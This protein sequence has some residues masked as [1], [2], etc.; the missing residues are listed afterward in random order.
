VLIEP[1]Y[2]GYRIEVFATAVG[3][4]RWNATVRIRRLFT[5]ERP[6][7]EIVTCRKATEA[8]AEERAMIVAKRWVDVNPH[9]TMGV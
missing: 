8:L 2:V 5:E 9:H 7:V 1:G 4:G 3:G 6:H